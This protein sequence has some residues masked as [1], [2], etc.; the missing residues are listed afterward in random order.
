MALYFRSKVNGT[1]IGYFSAQRREHE[2]P[3]DG[4]CTYDVHVDDDEFVV[5][6]NYHDGAWVL[7]QKALEEANARTR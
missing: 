4:V 6:H 2:I 1:T 3:E 5:K 7:I